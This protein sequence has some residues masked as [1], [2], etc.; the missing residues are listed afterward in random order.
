M[1]AMQRISR[2]S[3]ILISIILA[4]LYIQTSGFEEGA[5]LQNPVLSAQ[6]AKAARAARAARS[7][8]HVAIMG[9]RG[10]ECQVFRSLRYAKMCQTA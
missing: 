10:G 3:R 1:V 4:L 7:E 2:I 6:R 8:F 9:S 5:S